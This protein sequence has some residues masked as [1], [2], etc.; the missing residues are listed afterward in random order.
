MKVV[1]GE[2][3][4]P[5]KIQGSPLQNFFHNCP[6]TSFYCASGRLTPPETDA[7]LGVENSISSRHTKINFL[8]PMNT[9]ERG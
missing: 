7:G 2:M 6:R 8:T 5:S 9:S 3:M 1:A 4:L